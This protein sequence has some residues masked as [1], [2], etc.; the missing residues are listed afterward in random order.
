LEGRTPG[1]PLTFGRLTTDDT[2]GMIR[3]YFGE[4]ELT[5]DQLNTFGNRAVAHVPKLQKLMRHI[6][7]EGFEHHVVMNSSRT[8]AVLTEACERYLGW[9]VYHHE[10]PDV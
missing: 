10:A 3:A 6:C 1:G 5:N 4:G 2:A 8:A 7:N 9:E